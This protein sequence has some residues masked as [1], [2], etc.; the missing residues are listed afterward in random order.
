MREE[1]IEFIKRRFPAEDRWLNGN[2]LWF[3]II[4]CT[5]FEQLEIYYL[6]ID[7]H[8]VAGYNGEY[9]DWRGQIELEE[10]PMKL[11]DL[12]HEDELLHSHLVRDC[13]L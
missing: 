9:Y 2:C 11:A 6:P 4:L 8:F 13:Y 10:E 12:Q 7:G 5:R 1:I 3:A